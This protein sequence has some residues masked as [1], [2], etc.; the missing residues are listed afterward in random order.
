MPC[1]QYLSGK[2]TTVLIPQR[3][4]RQCASMALTV[5]RACVMHCC[6]TVPRSWPWIVLEMAISVSC[7]STNLPLPIGCWVETRH[8]ICIP[9]W[10]VPRYY[11]VWCC[12]E[13][14]WWSRSRPSFS[15]IY[16]NL[17]WNSFTRGQPSNKWVRVSMVGDKSTRENHDFS[18][19]LLLSSLE[20]DRLLCGWS[21]NRNKRC[22]CKPAVHAIL[23][24]AWFEQLSLYCWWM[25]QSHP[26]MGNGCDFWCNRGW[27]GERDS[28]RIFKC[29]ELS[30]WHRN[31]FRWQFV[32]HR[33]RQSPSH[34]LGQWR[35]VG[36][37]HRRHNRWGLQTKNFAMHPHSF[38]GTSGL[39]NNQFNT[40]VLDFLDTMA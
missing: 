31:G 19:I 4:H 22:S 1:L 10:L 8:A 39:A 25:E 24:T 32:L 36:N 6:F 9:N 12:A 20:Y 37:H 23:H 29:V 27:S 28:G 21:D 3:M 13:F 7:L 11:P 15:I 2:W 35:I 17:H 18:R 34:V 30:C 33:S 16:S 14:A 40:H 26:K 5:T 38:A